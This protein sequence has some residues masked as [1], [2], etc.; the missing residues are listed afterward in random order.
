MSVNWKICDNCHH[1]V[2]IVAKKCPYCNNDSFK[3][4][5]DD[6]N[7]IKDE[8]NELY[9][10]CDLIDNRGFY[11]ENITPILSSFKSKG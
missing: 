7:S 2:N 3:F 5:N 1:K 9:E 8:I 4:L 10:Y 6:N 11:D